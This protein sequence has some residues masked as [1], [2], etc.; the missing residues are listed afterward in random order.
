MESFYGGH[1]GTSFTLRAAFE[2][3]AEMVSNFKQGRGY[4]GVWFGEYCVIATPN[5]NNAENGRVYR[6]GVN[7]N[8]NL[9]GAEFIGQFVG[10]SSGTP[11]FT[12]TDLA[13]MQ[14]TFGVDRDNALKG[15]ESISTYE[16][17]QSTYYYLAKDQKVDA[18]GNETYSGHGDLDPEGEYIF[19]RDTLPQVQQFQVNKGLVS[20][21]TNGTI[22][23][24]WYN[25]REN[26]NNTNSYFDVGLQIPY[27]VVEVDGVSV[28]PYN[29]DGSLKQNNEFITYVDSSKKKSSLPFYYP[30]DAKTARGVKGDSFQNFRLT[31]TEAE[32]TGTNTKVYY[33]NL[34]NTED[35]KL[36]N[37]QSSWIFDPVKMINNSNLY[38]SSDSNTD[39]NQYNLDNIGCFDYNKFFGTENQYSNALKD[40]RYTYTPGSALNSKKDIKI[41]V[42]DLY[43]F[44]RR[45]NPR[46]IPICLG[47]E[48]DI[49]QITEDDGLVTI[50]YTDGT[51][52]KFQIAY[53]KTIKIDKENGNV[54]TI[55]ANGPDEDVIETTQSGEN[56]LTWVKNVLVNKDGTITFVKTTGVETAEQKIKWVESI[57]NGS[58]T[59]E[60]KVTVT[61]NTLDANGKHETD[62]MTL[63]YPTTLTLSDDLTE[64]KRLVVTDTKNTSK[65]V[66]D[67]V[68]SIAD[69]FIG[70][71]W[72]LYTLFTAPEK[73]PVFSNIYIDSDGNLQRSTNTVSSVSDGTEFVFSAHPTAEN[74]YVVTCGTASANFSDL[75]TANNEPDRANKITSGCLLGS[76]VALKGPQ[77]DM[78]GRI[79]PAK[80][81]SKGNELTLYWK[82]VGPLADKKG[83]MYGYL[84][85]NH[86]AHTI[87]PTY[88]ETFG[89]A[90]DDQK[91]MFND[92]TGESN[93]YTIDT[94]TEY[95]N[96][97]HPNGLC[98]ENPGIIGLHNESITN[99]LIA[100]KLVYYLPQQGDQTVAWIFA[101]DYS[102]YG[103]T[104]AEGWNYLGTANSGSGLNLAIAEKEL[105][106]DSELQAL[107]GPAVCFV[108]TEWT[109][110]TMPKIISQNFWE[111]GVTR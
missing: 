42:V 44:S 56:A 52:F 5:L 54:Y 55:R 94:I 39:T 77:T 71:D 28:S 109:E 64:K 85:T 48:R 4:D 98:V 17:L 8:A 73:R 100:G 1:A 41:L 6:R 72:Y 111:P 37:N 38:Y 79:H 102:K 25:K 95:L 18:S 31:T 57:V 99:N 23:F 65:E 34:N 7:Y 50:T 14:A 104:S 61:Y 40:C 59:T 46:P 30:F 89:E 32:E 96:K 83:Y 82:K 105:R 88:P 76:W 91:D 3:V 29:E 19:K 78:T 87:D 10:P 13:S 60:G 20:G 101:Y 47:V 58:G 49:A 35:K 106:V 110:K 62:V 2:S 15:K 68:N 86:R 93:Y 22:D 70:E 69:S 97:Y 21:K 12:L 43:L 36:Y 27:P 16:G 11:N 9:G 63:A 53:V 51:L 67:P 33:L 74:D 92:P 26:G 81:D 24:S 45:R 103:D 107:N 108:Q 75:T 84:L 80:T 66:G 90:T